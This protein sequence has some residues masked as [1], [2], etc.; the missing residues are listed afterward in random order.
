MSRLPQL[1]PSPPSSLIFIILFTIMTGSVTG[2]PFRIVMIF[3]GIMANF[4]TVVLII[5]RPEVD[6]LP[7]SGLTL[8]INTILMFT[9]FSWE[10]FIERFGIVFPGWRLHTPPG[11]NF[12]PMRVTNLHQLVIGRPIFFN[13]S[14]SQGINFWV[15]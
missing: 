13:L 4:I 5:Y 3:G 9:I 8:N 12:S 14:I 2:P 6:Q 7:T 15:G 1:V 11:R 10:R